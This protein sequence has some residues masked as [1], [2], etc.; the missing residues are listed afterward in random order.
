[1]L[2]DQKIASYPTAVVSIGEG[3]KGSNKTMC[4]DYLSDLKD[5][6]PKAIIIFLVMNCHIQIRTRCSVGEVNT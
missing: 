2:L 5:G 6:F 3:V 1:M 4:T